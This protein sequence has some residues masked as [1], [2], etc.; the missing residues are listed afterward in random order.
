MV[1]AYGKREQRPDIMSP[2]A[3]AQKHPKNAHADVFSGT[4][5]SNVGIA[6]QFHP[7]FV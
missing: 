5:G 1:N 2:I 3:N 6:L 7:Y 4:R